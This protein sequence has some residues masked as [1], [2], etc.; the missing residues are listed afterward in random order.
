MGLPLP[1][2][3]QPQAVLPSEA[4]LEA[5]PP[6]ICRTIL[7]RNRMLRG[8]LSMQQPQPHAGL[9][10]SAYMQVTSPIRRY[11]DL[12]AHWQLKVGGALD[13]TG[14]LSFAS[15]ADNAG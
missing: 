10:L 13:H 8:S 1:Y 12:L 6:G 14:S 5:V 2:R 7:R 3:G 4:E 9:G 15:S 11:G